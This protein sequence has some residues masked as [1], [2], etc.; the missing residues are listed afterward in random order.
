MH[1]IDQRIVKF[2]LEH[3]IF[4]LAVTNGMQPWC[5][6]CFYVYNETDNLFIFTSED[7]TLHIR[8]VEETNNFL[9]GGA[10]ALE[11]KMIGKIRGIQF[12]GM[13]RRLE[14]NELDQARKQY[15]HKFPVAL[16]S[17]LFL[18]GLQ[19]GFI[20]MTDNRLG[21]GKKL[22]WPQETP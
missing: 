6:T 21:F 3:H 4:T 18:W 9:A 8:Y 12:S 10:I 19:P 7:D 5:A 14:G 11:T 2:I 1:G 22:K 13:L 15:L 16:F 17:K 20:K